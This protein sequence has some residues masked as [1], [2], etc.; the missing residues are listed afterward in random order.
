MSFSRLRVA[1]S[2]A[3]TLAVESG[4]PPRT[5]QD[6]PS[7]SFTLCILGADDG[8]SGAAW[9][10]RALNISTALTSWAVRD[11]GGDLASGVRTDLFT[12]ARNVGGLSLAYDR[13]AR[14]SADA[15]CGKAGTARI[16]PPGPSFDWLRG[17]IGDRAEGNASLFTFLPGWLPLP[18]GGSIGADGRVASVTLVSEGGDTCALRCRYVIEG[19]SEGYALRAFNQSVRFGREGVRTGANCSDVT[20]CGESL[21]GRRVFGPCSP[22]RE[23]CNSTPTIMGLAPRWAN[24]SDEGEEVEDVSSAASAI[25]TLRRYASAL[26]A[27]PPDAPWL[28]HT[29]PTGFENGS[30]TFIRSAGFEGC[31]TQVGDVCRAEFEHAAG[32]PRWYE[33]P[34]PTTPGG[35]P[36]HYL[37]LPGSPWPPKRAVDRRNFWYATAALFYLQ[38]FVPGG[39]V[40]GLDNASYAATGA[41]VTAADVGAAAVG[42]AAYEQLSCRLYRRVTARLASPRDAVGGEAML[43]RPLFEPSAAAVSRTFWDP[44]SLGVPLY[45]I[46][47]RGVLLDTVPLPA[48]AGPEGLVSLVYGHLGGTDAH[49]LARRVLEPDAAAGGARVRNLLSPGAPRA[50]FQAQAALRIHAT[51]SNLGV[52]A[53]AL[54]A[55]A[56]AVGHGAVDA[57][58][59]ALAQFF[60][61]RLG[62]TLALV[63]AGLAGTAA[64]ALAQLPAALGVPPLNLAGYDPSTWAP[65]LPRRAN[66]TLWFAMYACGLREGA[67][68]RWP[69]VEGGGT[70]L[71]PPPP[72]PAGVT[73]PWADATDAALLTRRDVAAWLDAVL[74]G[75][76]AAVLASPLAEPDA[77]AHLRDLRAVLTR[78]MLVAAGGAALAASGLAPYAFP[79]YALVDSFEYAAAAPHAA[80]ELPVDAPP[81]DTSPGLSIS[82]GVLVR[83]ASAPTDAVLARVCAAPLLVPTGTGAWWP[84]FSVEADFALEQ[85]PVPRGSASVEFAGLYF[86]YAG[87]AVGDHGFFGLA[88]DAGSSGADG[89]A[90]AGFDGAQTLS[91]ALRLPGG[92]LLTAILPWPDGAAAV[93]SLRVEHDGA[94]SIVARVNGAEVLRATAAVPPLPSAAAPA[95]GLRVGEGPGRTVWGSVVVTLV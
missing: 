53:V 30:F 13:F 67:I 8:G 25:L 54:V 36:V 70:V 56:E 78:Q 42:G 39:S 37:R 72:L 43:A 40:W 87:P 66:A 33:Q 50:T 79:A 45:P 14:R 49:G 60:M 20:N 47:Y 80:P 11:I 90:G 61:A 76:S 64:F 51:A 62:G 82:A 2:L 55:A 35:P 73:R 84:A 18:G 95:F 74:P 75:S 12:S 3:L 28:L 71:P 17:V 93:F 88:S 65:A 15:A 68:P 44:S 69:P 83:S 81:C 29:A 4:E 34:D 16:A 92:D 94:G 46:D 6:C 58:P 48:W 89:P 31:L 24:V 26:D 38:K 5:S 23:V 21:A 77:P 59:T 91:W 22:P 10:A 85:V 9:A 86:L 7:Q 27:V 57:A 32:L 52:A 19:T 1:L 63:D 41:C